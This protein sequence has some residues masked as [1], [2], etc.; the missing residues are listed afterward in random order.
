MVSKLT[1][2]LI[3]AVIIDH[4]ADLGMALSAVMFAAIG[5]A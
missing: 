3:L 4:D 2:V 5:T 1:A